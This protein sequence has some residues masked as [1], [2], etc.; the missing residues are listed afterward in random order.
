MLEL[1]RSSISFFEEDKHETPISRWS[2]AGTRA[3]KIGKGLSKN[4]KAQILFFPHWLEAIDPQHRYGHNLNFYY[5]KWLESSSKQPFFYWLD[6][7]EGKEINI[8]EKCPRTKLQQQCVKY[9]DSLERMCYEVMVN[10]DGKLVYK[11]TNV[12]VNTRKDSKWIFV[13]STSMVLYIG[14][15]KKGCFQHSSFLSGAATSAAGRIIVDNGLLKAV[16]PYSGHYRPNPENFQDFIAFLE[17]NNVD[18][19]DVKLEVGKETIIRKHESYNRVIE[20]LSCKWRSIGAGRKPNLSSRGESVG[21]D[22]SS[23]EM[24]MM[25]KKMSLSGGNLRCGFPFTTSPLHKFSSRMMIDR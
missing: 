8:V 21:S 9:L 4:N 12:F 17:G 20:E 25:M 15:K 23:N 14:K 6:I 18:L 24:M 19:T 16:W 11:Q 5:E 13:L 1:K 3:A 22:S 10:D 2:R 7:G